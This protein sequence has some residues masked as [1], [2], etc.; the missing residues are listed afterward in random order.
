MLE[1]CYE[2][3]QEEKAGEIT[4]TK[5]LVKRLQL[6]PYTLFEKLVC[7]AK[8]DWDYDIGDRYV[9]LMNNEIYEVDEYS[10]S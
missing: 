10:K 5:S 3:S 2:I 8:R 1:S 4:K 9:L 6:M 7:L